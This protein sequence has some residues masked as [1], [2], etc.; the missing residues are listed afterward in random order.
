MSVDRILSVESGG[1]AYAR[2][3]RS[4]ATGAGQFIESTW[5][6]MMSRH[7]PDIITGMSRDQILNL[8]TDPALSR[9]MTEAY[10]NENKG[11]LGN[12]GV[13]VTDGTAYLAHFAGPQGAIKVLKADPTAPAG[14]ILGPA[15]VKA[16]PFLANMTA[17]DLAKWADKKMGAP[18]APMSSPNNQISAPTA[19]GAPISAPVNGGMPSP[20]QAP[21]AAPM[22]GPQGLLTQPP[23]AAPQGLAPEPAQQ[24]LLGGGMSPEQMQAFMAPPKPLQHLEIPMARPKK[25]GFSLRG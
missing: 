3:P 13:P 12:A 9:E 19:I 20:Q 17:G 18:A 16:N 15:V 25:A 24:G 5:L 8:R 23:Q 2:N 10:S 14:G 6:D 4:T 11:L 7:R 1:N 22:G 21:K